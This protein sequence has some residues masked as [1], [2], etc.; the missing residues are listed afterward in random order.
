VATTSVKPSTSYPTT[1][2]DD[3]L[4][5]R[6]RSI[7]REATET[8]DPE[9]RRS[10]LIAQGTDFGVW[11]MDNPT[12]AR[13]KAITMCVTGLR[14]ALSIV[15]RD[16]PH[17][18]DLLTAIVQIFRD[19]VQSGTDAWHRKQRLE[20]QVAWRNLEAKYR[21]RVF[22]MV[23]DKIR[24]VPLALAEAVMEEGMFMCVDLGSRSQFYEYSSR[25]G[26]WIAISPK[27]IER[28]AIGITGEG[29]SAT[30]AKST[31]SM[32]A[33]ITLVD[34]ADLNAH[35]Y[36]INLANGTYDLESDQLRPHDPRDRFT[37]AC[38]YDYDPTATCPTIDAMIR[39]YSLGDSQW[40]D[41]WWE[42]V[43]Y[44]LTEP[45]HI[46]KM[47]WMVGDGANGKSTCQRLLREIVGTHLTKAGFQLRDMVKDFF[48]TSVIGKRLALCGDAAVRM[49]NLDLLKQYTGG[50]ELDTNV[51][52]GDY[53]KV[54]PTAKLVLSMNRA[55]L[56][57]S[58]E[59][60]KPIA[61]RILWLPFDFRIKEP[62]PTIEDRMMLELAGAFN[63]AVEGWRRLKA[64]G[65]F[66]VVD[67]GTKALEIWTGQANML[68]VF[69]EM[70]VAVDE[71]S[72]VFL[73]EVWQDYQQF[74][75]EWATTNWAS[76]RFNITS[77]IVLSREIMARI[78]TIRKEMR[79]TTIWDGATSKKGRYP[80]LYGI[81]LVDQST[82]NEVFPEHEAF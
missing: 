11:L 61:R 66:T 15:L 10:T 32:I 37:Y 29:G 72:G 62:D 42:L 30:M 33:A 34:E 63:R 75:D 69:L 71:D 22:K 65:R 3:E 60:T 73:H 70:R 58:F 17:R 1:T 56:L 40:V 38:D 77:S 68:S 52:F 23:G 2:L 5:R 39:E 49:D 48:W 55:P 50:D 74:M 24:I 18:D 21:D 53:K 26:H 81:K 4:L 45:Y 7:I 54:K 36:R 82:Q 64:N 41:C 13:H 79:Y 28:L 35:P 47:C 43:G 59:A 6:L 80:F 8:T 67:R 16:E 51:K 12:V 14:E 78:P 19:A 25:D 57:S 44:C 27:R 76:D 46:S 31:A 9:I 20:E